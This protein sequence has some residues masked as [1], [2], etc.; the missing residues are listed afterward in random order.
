MGMCPKGIIKSAYGG[1][2]RLLVVVVEYGGPS[3]TGREGREGGRVT[4]MRRQ[5]RVRGE[6]ESGE[7]DSAHPRR[8]LGTFVVLSSGRV[9]KVD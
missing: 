9:R 8:I 4:P 7:A 5:G 6:G 3:P 1:A 2:A